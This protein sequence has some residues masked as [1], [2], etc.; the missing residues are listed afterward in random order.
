MNEIPGLLC[1]IGKAYW[2][3]T[4][5]KHL[6]VASKIEDLYRVQYGIGMLNHTMRRIEE[7]V[8]LSTGIVQDALMDE[9]VT[10]IEFILL[11]FERH[12]ED[13]QAYGYQEHESVLS[14]DEKEQFLRARKLRRSYIQHLSAKW[15]R[16]NTL[17]FDNEGAEGKNVTKVAIGFKLQKDDGDVSHEVVVELPEGAKMAT[18]FFL[19]GQISLSCVKWETFETGVEKVLQC[20]YRELRDL[21]TK[22]ITEFNSLQKAERKKFLIRLASPQTNSVGSSPSH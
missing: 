19:E 14:Q 11:R 18:P 17:V 7:D 3:D 2:S 1:G 6:N 12:T 9:A 4:R 8:E 21:Q 13:G 20:L 15:M 16:E 10:W 22:M 5:A